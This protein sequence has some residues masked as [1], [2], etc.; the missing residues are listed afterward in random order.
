MKINH[1]PH[2]HYKGQN[3]TP[4]EKVE[5]KAV[6][7]ILQSKIPDE[8]REDSIVFELKHTNGCIQIAR[9]LAQKRGLNLKLADAAAALHDVY[10]IVKGTYKNHAAHS[11][12]IAEQILKETGGFSQAE[13]KTITEAVA[14]HSEKDIYTKKPYIELLKDADVFDCSLYKAAEGDYR[15]NKSEVIINEYIKRIKNVRKELG[16]NP[17]EVWRK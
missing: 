12:P 14:H 6:E 15:A 17:N 1:K 11:K 2:H 8:Q 10:V 5:R 3:L 7:L 4:A 13:I 16:L 9:I